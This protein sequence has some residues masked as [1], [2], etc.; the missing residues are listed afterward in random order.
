[1]RAKLG[2]ARDEEGDSTLLKDLLALLAAHHVDYTVF[3]RRLCTAA[4]G[5][6]QDSALALSFGNE[7]DAFGS[8]A[9]VWRR[10]LALE[11]DA[12][13]ARASAMRRVNPAFIPRNHRVE[14]ALEAAVRRNDF[15]PFETLV[16][17][18]G[19]PYDDQPDSASLADPPG[20][21]QHDYKTFCGT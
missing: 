14:E 8:W 15:E 7:P 10:R 20:P 18:L 17:V 21:E 5:A 19:R 1:M 2:F 12:P 9:E 4:A 16:R 13:Q 3:F 11:G 6:S